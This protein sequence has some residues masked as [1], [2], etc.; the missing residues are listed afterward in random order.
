[1]PDM[2]SIPDSRIASPLSSLQAAMLRGSL[3]E[4]TGANVEQVE[5]DFASDLCMGN[6]LEAWA[7]TVERTEV[8]RA[9]FLIEDGE[10]THIRIGFA[11][12]PLLIEK[13][14]PSSWKA[15]LA[16]DR[17][18][19]LPLN[20]ACPWRVVAWPDARKLVWTF[21]HALLDGRSIAT[22]LRT[23]QDILT[24]SSEPSDTR[25][26]T[27]R[28]PSDDEIACAEKFHRTAFSGVD[29]SLPEFPA[30]CSNE[31]AC[32]SSCLGAVA[33][34]NLEAA[35]LRME[36]TAATLL[37][38]AWGQ[39]VACASGQDSVAVGQVRSGVAK[40][41]QAGFT[42]NT[43]PLVIDRAPQVP[44]TPVIQ[45]FRETLLEM[46]EVET[47]SPQDLPSAIFDHPGGPWPGGVVMIQRGTLHHQVG[48]SAAVRAITLHETSNEPLLASAWIHPDQIGRAHV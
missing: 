14:I 34:A 32:F 12:A 9:A 21:H 48:A 22:I 17:M 35:A 27:T 7:L 45:K 25:L 1:M 24:G 15:W 19:P 47:V 40:P 3:D 29:S 18:N 46:R 38:W 44:V 36:V 28:A 26:A 33:A 43:V 5:M 31:P 10:A 6:V 39:A 4:W 13:E 2:I 37:T 23:F 30:D 41:G 42:M 16:E 11:S 20:R 8:L